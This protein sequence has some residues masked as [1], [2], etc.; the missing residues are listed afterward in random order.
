LSIA[1]R[2]IAEK[3]A[4]FYVMA[5][6]DI[7][8]FRVVND[9]YGSEKG[10]AVLR[11]IAGVFQ[12]GFE[13]A[14]GICCRVMADQFAVLYPKS[15]LES[16]TLAHMRREAAAFDGTIP[17]ITFSIGRYI[18]T[19]KTLPVSAMYDRAALAEAS[20]K[21]CFDVSIAQYDESMREELLL[22]QQII[23]EMQGALA[24]GQFEVWLQPQYNHASGAIIG[25]EALVRWR[26][27]QK[28]VLLP[29]EFLPLFE[30][31]GFVYE[32]D[33]F[34]W[35]R[36]CSLL[37]GWLDSGVEP[38]PISVNI[39]GYDAYRP[40]FFE[41]ITAIV[42]KYRVP[43]AF[44][45]LEITESA[46]ADFT[47][48]IILIVSRLTDYGFTV[49]IDDFGGG[50]SS[51]SILKDV[52]ASMLKLDMRL[53]ANTGNTQ[54]GGNILESVVRMTKWLGLPVIA[55]GVETR[56]Q[57]SFLKSIGCN[58]V[59]GYLYARPMPSSDFEAQLARAGREKTMPVIEALETLDNDAFWDPASMETLIFNSYV[60]GACIFAYDGEKT[61][62]LRANEKYA[63]ILFGSGASMERALTTE[64]R[65]Y[66]EESDKLRMHEAIQHAI[67]TG[68]E[69]ACELC[70]NDLTAGRE[71][72]YIRIALRVLAR[73]GV[74][75]LLYGS[76]IDITAQRVAEQRQREA[77]AQLRIIM[78][79]VNGGVSA[80]T[81]DDDG[82]INYIFAN[83][84]Y[85]SM[86]GYTREQ[87]AQE[88]Q[89][90]FKLVHPED[91]ERTLSTVRRVMR[92]R[93]PAV[94]EYRCN[95][96]DGTTV[97]VRCNA[98]VTSLEGVKGD[99]LLSVTT[100]ITPLVKAE[101]RLH[102][103]TNRL[104]A[105]MDNI[106]GG[107]TAVVIQNGKPMFLFANDQ[108][109][110]QLGY[111]KEQYMAEVPVAFDP[112]YPEDREMVAAITLQASE[113]REPFSCTYRVFRRDGSLAWM[114]S[115]ISIARFPD[116]EEPVQLAVANDVTAQKEAEERL[117]EATTELHRLNEQRKRILENLPCGAGVYEYTPEGLRVVYL[118]ERYRELVN[119]SVEELSPLPVLDVV[120]PDD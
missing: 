62:L 82:K 23:N 105:I 30:R 45:R 4:G 83:E 102:E 74:E 1:S 114:Q 38:P 44:L 104:Q 51:L 97:H 69:S 10:D 110:A 31:N 98:S 48:D 78:E 29:R 28:G 35:E 12:K 14:G 8:K 15:F 57:A 53:L 75:V 85:Y 43:V 65:D 66:M 42:E 115:N 86:F 18:V 70:L 73:A 91:R 67:E 16:E 27:P 94:Y 100:D 34:V 21:D 116:I 61:E 118:N 39:S 24:D 49:E 120:H 54:R 32:M 5:C 92:L 84:Q 47:D 2:M 60:G 111:T 107:V 76:V 58:Y 20:V 26:H 50:Y 89:D 90:A 36:V 55:E 59:Q 99:V 3:P 40:D 93:Q 25:A 95:K 46:F 112:V 96:R 106:N 119:R 17:P 71:R 87:Y 80:V 109:F 33:K 9:R 52:P 63:E 13:A 37:R 79:N 72:T 101:E 113:T 81:V 64:V 22:E 68:G 6:F 56:E 7:D 41:T 11:F 117:I 103:T 19:D 88:V 108:Y 77:F